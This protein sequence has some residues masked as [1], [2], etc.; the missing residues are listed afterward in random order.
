ML[1]RIQINTNTNGNEGQCNVR[2]RRNKCSHSM[3]NIRF[4]KHLFEM[5]SQTE[6]KKMGMRMGTDRYS[7]IVVR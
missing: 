3:A 6:Y 2:I 4:F 5:K 7:L 1:H